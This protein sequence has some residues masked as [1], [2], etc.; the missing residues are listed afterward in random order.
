M[1]HCQDA[2]G[3]DLT[4]RGE[5]KNPFTKPSGKMDEHCPLFIE[6]LDLPIKGGDVP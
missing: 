5:M 2:V 1:C 6:F 4:A 3:M